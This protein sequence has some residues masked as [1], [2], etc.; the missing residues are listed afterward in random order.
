MMVEKPSVVEESGRGI[1]A[2]VYRVIYKYFVSRVKICIIAIYGG[3]YAA[4]CSYSTRSVIKSRKTH[5]PLTLSSSM[6]CG[7]CFR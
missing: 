1:A 7:H 3:T 2:F 6:Q 4:C 5:D